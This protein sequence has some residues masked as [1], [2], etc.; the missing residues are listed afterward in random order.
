MRKLLGIQKCNGWMDGHTDQ[1]TDQPTDQ[2]GKVQSC[3]SATKKSFEEQVEFDNHTTDANCLSSR[4]LSFLTS[5]M[6]S[7]N[8]CVISVT[9]NARPAW[10][11]APNFVGNDGR[12][13]FF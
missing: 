4:S 10:K 1:P 5:L 8:F 7:F 11:K 12:K 2:H 9:E 3:V 6:M 13:V